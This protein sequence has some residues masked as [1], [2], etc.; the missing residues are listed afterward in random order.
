MFTNF[1]WMRLIRFIFELRVFLCCCCSFGFSF[2]FHRIGD[3]E[4]YAYLICL[5][6]TY[7]CAHLY[8]AAC[9]FLVFILFC[10]LPFLSPKSF[11]VLL[12]HN[13]KLDRYMHSNFINLFL[14]SHLPLDCA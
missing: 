4:S 6:V 5:R 8:V 13:F 12:K 1:R 11:S 2:L 7:I 10:S 3:C 9:V 14:I